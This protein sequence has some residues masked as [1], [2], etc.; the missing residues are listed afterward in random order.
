MLLWQ[1]CVKSFLKLAA[2]S[3]WSSSMTIC[4]VARAGK[5]LVMSKKTDQLDDDAQPITRHE[6]SGE[7]LEKKPGG[8]LGILQASTKPFPAIEQ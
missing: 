8:N 7:I 4:L 3:G 1:P 2:P 6:E 5:K